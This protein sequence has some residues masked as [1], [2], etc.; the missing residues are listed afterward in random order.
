MG[1]G[2]MG[3]HD[4][5]A[6]VAVLPSVS[7]SVIALNGRQLSKWYFVSKQA[8]DA[9]ACAAYNAAI[10]TNPL[11]PLPPAYPRDEMAMTLSFYYNERPPA[12]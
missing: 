3:V 2:T 5:S 11:E 1:V 9:S 8:I 4:G 10:K 7:A 6:A 12:K